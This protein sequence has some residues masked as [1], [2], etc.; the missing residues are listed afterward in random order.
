L[1]L[2]HSEK[3]DED[4]KSDQMELDEQVVQKRDKEDLSE[5][6]LD[7]YDKESTKKSEQLWIAFGGF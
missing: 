3:S 2:C 7:D 6:K 5:Y 4:E 1:T